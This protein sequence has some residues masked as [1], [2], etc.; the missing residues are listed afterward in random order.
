MMAWIGNETGE[1]LDTQAVA[2][3]CET[4]ECKDLTSGMLG[5]N[6]QGNVGSC[7]SRR[8]ASSYD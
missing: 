7:W 6:A 1:R 3:W 2:H 4:S 5:I 8:G